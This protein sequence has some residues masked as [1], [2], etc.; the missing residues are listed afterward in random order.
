LTDN[1][2]PLDELACLVGRVRASKSLSYPEVR[3]RGGPAM[4]WVQRLETGQMTDRPKPATIAKLARG[5]GVD[6][7]HLMRL[8]GYE[9]F[10]PAKSSPSVGKGSTEGIPIPVGDLGI[11]VVPLFAATAGVPFMWTAESRGSVPI[12][13]DLIGEVDG[14]FIVRGNSVSGRGVMD[15]AI[16]LVKRLPDGERPQSGKLVV[17]ESEGAFLVKVFR[18]GPGGEYLESHEAGKA[19]EPVLFTDDVRLVGLVVAVQTRV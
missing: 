2:P 6:Y 16:V 18:V 17:V 11:G 1:N 12:S 15:G 4:S 9:G 7:A 8:A 3:A 10:G 14:A 13:G 19:P 5:L